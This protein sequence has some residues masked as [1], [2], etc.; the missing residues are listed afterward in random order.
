M[1]VQL[2]PNEPGSV[3]RGTLYIIPFIRILAPAGTP[4]VIWSSVVMGEH[5]IHAVSIDVEVEPPVGV[6][7]MVGVAGQPT[8]LDDR[9]ELAVLRQVPR[10]IDMIFAD[11]GIDAEFQPL[12]VILS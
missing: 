7:D 11:S 4:A 1:S 3:V 2:I 10:L 8:A 9:P 12:H 5:L 6:M